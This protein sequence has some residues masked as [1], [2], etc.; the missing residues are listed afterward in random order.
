[1]NLSAKVI[2]NLIGS[3]VSDSNLNS[4]CC[5]DELLKKMKKVNLLDFVS[6]PPSVS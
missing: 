2:K 6:I 5:K 4:E 3:I 1:M